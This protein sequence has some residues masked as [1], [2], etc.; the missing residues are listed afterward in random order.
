MLD[1]L[2]QKVEETIDYIYNEFSELER[3]EEDLL[4]YI[5]ALSYIENVINHFN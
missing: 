3:K 4:E 2:L 5:E 1:E